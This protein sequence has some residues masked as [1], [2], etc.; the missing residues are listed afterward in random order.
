MLTRMSIFRATDLKPLQLAPEMLCQRT[1]KF[2]NW[3]HGFCGL[4]RFATSSP[5]METQKPP[6]TGADNALRQQAVRC[7]ILM[8]VKTFTK[9]MFTMQFTRLR[10]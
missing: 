2:L 3:I 9:Q 4:S 1:N 8:S 6:L 7:R 10:K 5:T